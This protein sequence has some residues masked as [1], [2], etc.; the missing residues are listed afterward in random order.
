M[1]RAFY[2]PAAS[3]LLPQTVPPEIFTSAATWN[4]TAWQLASILG[5]AFAGVMVALLG[6]VTVI[7]VLDAVAGITFLILV[8]LIKGRAAGALAEQSRDD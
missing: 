2:Q 6:S 5:P 7:Y 8:S 1:A 4:S 3:T